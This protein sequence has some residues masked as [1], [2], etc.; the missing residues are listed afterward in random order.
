MPPLVRLPIVLG[1]WAAVA[2]WLVTYVVRRI[3]GASDSDP[4]ICTNIV[5][6]VISCDDG[7][8][9]WWLDA[10]GVAALAFVVVAGA[11]L[12]VGRARSLATRR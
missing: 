11:T 4:P 9:S 8:G 5:G 10:F 2:G 6:S 1:S 12:L 3:A 7:V